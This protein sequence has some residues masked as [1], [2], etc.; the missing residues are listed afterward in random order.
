MVLAGATA[1]FL[2]YNFHPAT[3]FLGDS[4]SLFLGFM[5]AGIGLLSAQ[6]SSTVVAVAIPVVSLG[7]PV[8]DTLLAVFR[9]F[10][11]GQPISPRIVGTSTT[12]LLGH[13]YSPRTVVLA[14][15]A[16]CAVLAMR[17]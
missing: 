9:R 17:P 11:R 7:L 14:L 15:Y 5:L 1:G 4:G 6:K 13:G 2:F 8:L 12:G 3:I 16:A 10:L